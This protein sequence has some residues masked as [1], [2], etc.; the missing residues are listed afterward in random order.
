ML[1][2]PAAVP[3]P[4]LTPSLPLQGVPTV[5]SVGQ[6]LSEMGPITTS[7][8]SLLQE[9]LDVGRIGDEG[10]K[11]LKQRMLQVRAGGGGRLGASCLCEW[12]DGWMGV[13]AKACQQN[14]L[15]VRGGW[16]LS[17]TYAA[18]HMLV[19][20]QMCSCGCRPRR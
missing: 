18:H 7:Q 6:A 17:A 9:H 19:G 10:K 15:Q 4:P 2:R 8:L 16:E 11:L 3:I 12:V 14:M 5:E 1:L 20:W 13:C